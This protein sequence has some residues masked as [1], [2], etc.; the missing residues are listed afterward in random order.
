MTHTSRQRLL[1]GA[2][3]PQFKKRQA[4]LQT[5]KAATGTDPSAAPTF[6]V[7]VHGLQGPDECIPQA[8]AV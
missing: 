8:Q 3:S 1:H 7:E 6:R 4:C 5:M 2:A